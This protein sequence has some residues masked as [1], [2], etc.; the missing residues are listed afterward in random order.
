MGCELVLRRQSAFESGHDKAVAKRGDQAHR[1]QRIVRR[2]DRLFFLLCVGV[3]LLGPLFCLRWLWPLVIA[4]DAF[5]WTE[6]KCWTF[7]AAGN[8]CNGTQSHRTSPIYDVFE[9]GR[10][11]R[12]ECWPPS[13]N[14]LTK[15]LCYM[16]CCATRIDHRTQIQLTTIVSTNSPTVQSIKVDLLW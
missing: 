16:C 11:R 10:L 14:Q 1:V 3:C 6:R 15:N 12:T 9:A 2:R 8:D 13:N 5:K 4:N 7:L